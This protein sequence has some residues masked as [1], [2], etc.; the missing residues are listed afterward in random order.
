LRLQAFFIALLF[1]TPFFGV[2]Q[3]AKELK[4]DANKLFEQEQFVEATPLF[5]RL[6]AIEPKNHEYNFKYGTCL[7]FQSN[8]KQ[9]ALNYLQYAVKSS[10]IQ[11]DAFFYLGRAYHLNYLFKEAVKSYTKFIALAPNT[12]LKY[13][14]ER[15]TNMCQNGK[16][17]LTKFTDFEVID[18]QEIAS[19]EFY[20]SYKLTQL[21]GELIV[22]AEFQ[23]K[24]D[25]KKNHLPLVY[26]G[27][28]STSIYYASYGEDATTG[29]DIY[30]RTKVKNGGW[31]EPIKLSASINTSFDENYPFFN[32]K[33]RELFFSS[34]SYESIGGYDIFKAK[35]LNDDQF[36]KPKAIDFAIS[37]SDDDL[38]YISDSLDQLAFFASTRNCEAG[39]I[40]LYTI[41]NERFIQN[42]RL[43]KGDFVST[44]ENG[45]SI[46]VIQ[47]KTGQTI[48]NFST[49]ENKGYY[50]LF[51]EPG[52]YTFVCKLASKSSIIPL[53]VEIPASSNRLPLA[54][55]IVHERVGGE[56][57][58]SLFNSDT[59]TAQNSPELLADLI[60]QK[61]TLERS[62]SPMTGEKVNTE[63][64]PELAVKV[65]QQEVELHKKIALKTENLSAV[66]AEVAT[67]EKAFDYAI[68]LKNKRL[69]ELNQSLKALI[70][71]YNNE[72]V[73]DKKQAILQDANQLVNDLKKVEEQKEALL[74]LKQQ[75]LAPVKQ[76]L[77]AVDHL[78]IIPILEKLSTAVAAKTPSNLSPTEHAALENFQARKL[79]TPAENF[80]ALQDSLSEKQQKLKASLLSNAKEISALQNT[81]LQLDQ[82]LEQASDKK[83][84]ALEE[85]KNSAVS[86]LK[87]YQEEQSVVTKKIT[88]LQDK[89]NDIQ[90]K[91]TALSAVLATEIPVLSSVKELLAASQQQVATNNSSTLQDFIALT[92]QKNPLPPVSTTL[93]Q[94]FE[95]E[96]KSHQQAL[97]KI[98]Q[99]KANEAVKQE[100]LTTQNKKFIARLDELDSQLEEQTL[101]TLSTKE[102]DIL[103]Q[104]AQRIQQ[105]KEATVVTIADHS[106]DSDASKLEKSPLASANQ[107][108]KVSIEEQLKS[109][110]FKSTNKLKAIEANTALE[111]AEKMQLI[112]QENRSMQ[113]QE[114]S[115]SIQIEQLKSAEPTKDFSKERIELARLIKERAKNVQSA[116]QRIEQAANLTIQPQ[117]NPADS[118]SNALT[119]NVSKTDTSSRSSDENTTSSS[120]AINEFQRSLNLLQANFE[121]QIARIQVRTPE[122]KIKIIQEQ[123][124]AWRS[125]LEAKKETLTSSSLTLAEK[126]IVNQLIDSTIS[127]INQQLLQRSDEH[128]VQ[129][130]NLS[131]DQ[132]Q[133]NQEAYLR[134][135]GVV[136]P[137]MAILSGKSK[138]QKETQLIELQQAK[139]LLN[140]AQT[141][142]V[143]L[144][145][146]N[147]TD[148]QGISNQFYNEQ[149]LNSIEETQ[150]N[151]ENEIK[152]SEIEAKEQ[153]AQLAKSVDQE[154]PK[155][156]AP[157][158]AQKPLNPEK[159]N[160]SIAEKNNLLPSMSSVEAESDFVFKLRSS[161]KSKE[162]LTFNTQQDP[163][164]LQLKLKEWKRYNNYLTNQLKEVE[165]RTISK[166][167]VELEKKWIAAEIDQVQ[168]NT[169][170]LTRLIASKTK[171]NAISSKQTLPENSVLK[172][173]DPTDPNE[174]F[175]PMDVTLPK[176][177]LY[178]VQIGA[179]T[180]PMLAGNHPSIEP[181]SGERMRNGWYRYL[182]GY[183]GSLDQAITA[184]TYIRQN[185]FADAYLVAYCDG[186]KISL[187]QAS[188]YIYNGMCKP[189][190]GTTEVLANV[191]RKKPIEDN[192][193]TETATNPNPTFI[194]VSDLPAYFKGVNTVA[195]TPLETISGLLFSVQIG[196]FS[197]PATAEITKDLSPLYTFLL[198]NKHIRY[199]V[200]KFDRLSDALEQKK[201]VIEKGF[202]DAFIVIYYNG[203]RITLQAAQQL[204]QS[205]GNAVFANS[206][207][208]QAE[209]ISEASPAI[210]SEIVPDVLPVE[211]ATIEKIVH[212]QFVSKKSFSAFP[213]DVLNRYNSKGTFY[214]DPSDG[215]VKSAIVPTKEALPRVF[216]FKNDVDTLEIISNKNEVTTEIN[217]NF[218]NQTIAGDVADWLQ[219]LPYSMHFTNDE[220]GCL[221]KIVGVKQEELEAI[222]K[223][224][225]RFELNFIVQKK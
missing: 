57:R 104:L 110:H 46:T 35:Q 122:E 192:V 139:T 208:V 61:A 190:N 191:N 201:K 148:I 130:T 137:V 50:F 88:L 21:G 26:F 101:P 11:P 188:E 39:K 4:S 193:T 140:A 17:K 156:E 81:I 90:T 187:Q 119:S 64:Q 96:Q 89:I 151:L 199:S 214:Y 105:V 133:Q 69:I 129:L 170:E 158:P 159:N 2:G 44:L 23:T 123:A 210:S 7:L 197:V 164:L 211:P 198:P 73:Q 173:G 10:E 29:L 8:D 97:E 149:L 25:K 182:S 177:L 153:A 93:V 166:S 34:N 168:Q 94:K 121:Q 98:Q 63:N 48:G 117:E 220:S 163:A 136:T 205:K 204:I 58:L 70:V 77:S 30:K 84:S 178:R 20:R 146:K 215:K 184:Q 144:Q 171:A 194:A 108:S 145:Q 95:N 55:Q 114:D 200:G 78:Q 36:T 169:T 213:I 152:L 141:K 218:V 12:K 16:N 180:K 111:A 65:L 38:L 71:A 179:F 86:T 186:Q 143:V 1:F 202:K 52:A 6:L 181:I 106:K 67:I 32:E 203:E 41:K 167:E 162:I 99:S 189:Y 40:N 221:L 92:V 102:Q 147:P 128:K 196:A 74:T 142:E 138:L 79:Q 87:T 76:Q 91:N 183:F 62:T 14:A 82:Q 118:I 126:A 115:I 131:E 222:E 212:Y 72:K 31:S 33:T 124:I 22:V 132:L 219:R 116:I 209:N 9:K 75:S 56:D 28:G 80:I 225:N 60:R 68:Y 174:S 3:T 45:I 27:L 53:K 113:V 43:V 24:L 66:N 134:K 161:F 125:Q 127:T 109:L 5:S 51:P 176:G 100:L 175:I 172:F 216:S 107:Q 150:Q 224:L 195:A 54:Q 135:I 37:S 19:E 206:V 157:E 154:T 47:Q 165:G 112:E 85:Q 59:I 49:N 42:D 160:E 155:K 103:G 185:G 120:D 15:Y 83:K 18:K 207:A 223:Q 13:T 217:V